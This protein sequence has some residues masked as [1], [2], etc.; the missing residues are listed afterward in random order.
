MKWLVALVVAAAGLALPAGALAIETATAGYVEQQLVRHYNTSDGYRVQS[1]ICS[2]RNRFA[3]ARG[4]IFSAAWNCL[5][6]DVL[7]RTF[8][9]HATVVNAPGA[10][11][12]RPIQYRCSAVYSRFRCP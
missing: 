7:S 10:G 2:P 6:V 12:Q 9:L 8:W 11:I 5:E 3:V 4:R 1:A